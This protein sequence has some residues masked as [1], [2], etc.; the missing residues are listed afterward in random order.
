MPVFVV[1]VLV[2]V[3][4]SWVNFV[5]LRRVYASNWIY[6]V[7]RTVRG[8][9]SYFIFLMRTWMLSAVTAINC[10]FL[11]LYVFGGNLSQS[12]ITPWCIGAMI[13]VAALHL[14]VERKRLGKI[15]WDEA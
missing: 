10:V 13:A 7:L 1:S 2:Y 11:I 8:P 4:L 15:A 14:F 6:N 3:G 12:D 5:N 9:L